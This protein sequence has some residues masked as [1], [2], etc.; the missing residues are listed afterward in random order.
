MGRWAKYSLSLA[1]AGACA[2]TV[3]AGAAVTRS[4]PSLVKMDEAP[5]SPPTV[6]PAGPLV[7]LTDLEPGDSRTASFTLGNPNPTD[8][9]AHISGA[10]TSG[11]QALYDVLNVE[12]SS[13]DGTFWNGPLSGMVGSSAAKTKIAAD[14]DAPLTLRL[15]VPPDVG[16]AY[17]SKLSEFSLRFALERTA[18]RGADKRPPITRLRSIKPGPRILRRSRSASRM[19][20]RKQVIIFTGRTADEYSGIDRVEVSLMRIRRLPGKKR[21]CKSWS[22]SSRLYVQRGTRANSCTRPIWFSASGTDEFRFLMFGSR[23]IRKGHYRIRVR[24]T[25]R[26]G[27]V[28]SLYNTKKRNSVYFRIG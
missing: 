22:P 15:S 7:S 19:R 16:N 17:Q 23:M 13:P 14:G 11:D 28:E 6:S 25:D 24:A 2:V 3:V 4:G 21:V 12:L 9:D 26:A 10:L 8:T 27:N 5:L 18:P 1:V 20:R